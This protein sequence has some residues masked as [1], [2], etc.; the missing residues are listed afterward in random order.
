LSSPIESSVAM[1]GGFV[2]NRFSNSW[3]NSLRYFENGISRNT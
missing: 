1:R 2:T 3:L